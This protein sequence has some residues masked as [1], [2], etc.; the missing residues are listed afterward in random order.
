MVG[1]VTSLASVFSSKFADLSVHKG[2]HWNELVPSSPT[3]ITTHLIYF[4]LGA[5]IVCFSLVSHVIK[6]K[7]Y[8]S[9]ALVATIFG[10][11]I[12]PIAGNIF[13][14]DKLFPGQVGTV[15]LEV[16]RFVIAVQC[17]VAGIT[18]P[19][20]YIAR[21]WKSLAM[22]LGPV[23]VYMWI[24]SAVGIWL[25]LG[26]PWYVSLVVGACVTPTDPVLCNSIV[27]GPF[28]EKRIPSHVRL[29]LSAESALNDGLGLPFLF[30]P[31]YLFRLSNTGEA[32]G[33]W[34]VNVMLYQIILAAVIGIII[35]LSSC[36]ALKVAAKNNWIDK[37]SILGF[38]IAIALFSM[39]LMSLMGVDDVFGCFVVGTVISWDQWFNEKVE[40]SQIQEVIDSLI[41]LA[42]F[43][44]VAT[45]MPW[46]DFVSMEG[47]PFW[48]MIVLA[49]WMLVLRRLPAVMALQK[50][51]P[52]L[53]NN[54]EAFFCGWFGPVGAGAIFYSMIAIVYLEIDPMP[55]VPIVFFVVLS[56]IVLHGSSVPLFE[57]SLTRH[58]LRKKLKGS[59]E[60]ITAINM[61]QHDA[62]KH[63]AE[64]NE[65][66][67]NVEEGVVLAEHPTF[68]AG[69]VNASAV[70][71]SGSSGGQGTLERAGSEASTVP[72][73][74]STGS[75]LQAN[76]DEI[77][78]VA[79]PMDAAR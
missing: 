44:F 47:I 58:D 74:A 54:K 29:V 66:A 21:E 71:G 4:L 70:T 55:L 33:W 64:A 13:N 56:S 22:L 79:V 68:V 32:I 75:N 59:M 63:H 31:L 39:G 1:N 78:A 60:A 9:E 76:A 16:S 12:G 51:I 23:M 61:M 20:N 7:L 30:L 46:R 77:H 26:V 48:R 6:D 27:K 42:Y 62:Q 24:V 49:V 35:G 57:F 2:S 8:M 15:T 18:L 3:L 28:A 53:H 73:G 43:V 72:S 19:G 40:E 17:L 45:L 10:V 5:L 50:F 14:P 67:K 69:D 34:L 36:H 52:A 37:E 65:D 38:F 41:N 11:I 25:I